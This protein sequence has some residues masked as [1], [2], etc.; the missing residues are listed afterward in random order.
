M[1]GPGLVLTASNGSEIAIQ[2]VAAKDKKRRHIRVEPGRPLLLALGERESDL[3]EVA[4]D[5][6]TE[7]ATPKPIELVSKALLNSTLPGEIVLDPF[8]GGG[9]TLVACERTGRRCRAIELEPAH[10][11]GIVRRWEYVTARHATLHAEGV[12]TFAEVQA[13]RVGA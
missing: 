1:L 13:A 3:W 6:V 11:D 7:H 2:P 4:R 10:V 9:S 12:P 5:R 8:A